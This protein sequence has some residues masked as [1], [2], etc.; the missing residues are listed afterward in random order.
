MQ[1]P[2]QEA[3]QRMALEEH[4]AKTAKT[5]SETEEN[6]AQTEK[7]RAETRGEGVKAAHTAVKAQTELL[8]AVQG[9]QHQTQ[10]A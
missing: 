5:M 10:A 6:A 8:N 1:K 9:M 2:M 7:I 3:Q 4:Q